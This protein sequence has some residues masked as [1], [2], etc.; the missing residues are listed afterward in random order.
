MAN[1]K[2]T[3][4]VRADGQSGGTYGTGASAPGRQ[5]AWPPTPITATTQPRQFPEQTGGV[6]TD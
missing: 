5:P 1:L 4:G 3:T 6:S 2:H